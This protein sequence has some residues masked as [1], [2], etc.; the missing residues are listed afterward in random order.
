MVTAEFENVASKVLEPVGGVPARLVAIVPLI[1]D[2]SVALPVVGE[3]WLIVMLNGNAVTDAMPGPAKLA[4][5]SPRPT[6]VGV[7]G[8]IAEVGLPVNVNVTPLLTVVATVVAGAPP[9]EPVVKKLNGS[10]FATS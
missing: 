4:V 9:N 5:M 2:S 10:A 1:V 8:K 7:F 6:M 3:T